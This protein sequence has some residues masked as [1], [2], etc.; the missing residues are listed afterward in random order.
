MLPPCDYTGFMTAPRPIGWV[1][2]GERWGLWW[3]S[4][5]VASVQPDARGI[6][7]VLSCRKLWENKEVRAAS[8]RQGKRYAERWCAVRILEGVPMK[9]AVARLVA[10]DRQYG[11]APRSVQDAQQDRRWEAVLNALPGSRKVP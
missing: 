6:R 1:Q 8:V 7:V 10:V 2:H 11:R 9:E 4:R 5:E 3:C